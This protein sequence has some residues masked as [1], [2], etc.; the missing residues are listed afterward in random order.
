[1]RFPGFPERLAKASGISGKQ[2]TPDGGCILQIPDDKFRQGTPIGMLMIDNYT[3]LLVEDD[4]ND[5]LFLK[6]ALKKNGISNPISVLPD[7]DEAIAYLTGEGKYSDRHTYPFPKV[8]MLDLK[9]PRR[10]GLEVLEWLK[11]HPQYRVIP[12][13]VLTSSKIN[14][15]VVKAYGLGANSYMVKPSNFEDL[16][17]MIKVA[18]E[19]W[20]FCLKPEPARNGV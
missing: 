5:V 10:G 16:Q 14:E 11:E 1:L 13:L 3:I 18:Y 12:T 4:P 20:S 19:Y 7:G 6:R 9:M 15:D 8:I 2:D 17:Q